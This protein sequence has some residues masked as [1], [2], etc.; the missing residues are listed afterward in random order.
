M[1]STG[2]SK[3]KLHR[4]SLDLGS[5]R[6]TV[7][8][9]RPTTAARFA[10]TTYH[11]SS[12]VLCDAGGADLLGRLS[13]AM[14]FQT[15][16]HT[17]LLI[18]LPL[19][20]ADPFDTSPPSPIVIVNSDVD[21]PGAATIEALVAQLPLTDASQGSV[22]LTTAGFDRAVADVDRFWTQ[23]RDGD[24]E[25]A[26]H[27]HARWVEPVGGAV[28]L[29]APAPVLRQWAVR[30]AETAARGPLE[31]GWTPAAEQKWTGEV[32]ILAGNLADEATSKSD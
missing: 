19:I 32:K 26:A 24:P 2:G 10:T 11:Q 25:L 22:R 3:L 21:A 1:G 12:Y 18:D 23:E 4:R 5:E 15:R 7:L 30:V 20:A 14:A 27:Q 31:P 16:P 9:A 13:W 6:Y 28:V 29:A 8:S 17:L